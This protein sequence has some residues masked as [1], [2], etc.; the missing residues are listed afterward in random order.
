MKNFNTLLL[1]CALLLVYN[2]ALCAQGKISKIK[3]NSQ[4][5]EFNHLILSSIPSSLTAGFCFENTGSYP[6]VILS[7]E[8]GCNCL[9]AQWSKEPIEPGSKGSIVITF[10][11][12]K[13]KGTFNKRIIVKTNAIPAVICNNI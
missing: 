12:K 5:V 11:H 8:T 6:L 3:F 1:V 13:Q 9:K 4:I 2:S 10:D 7:V